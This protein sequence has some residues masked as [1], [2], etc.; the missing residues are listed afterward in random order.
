SVAVAAFGQKLKGVSAL[1]DYAYGSILGL[2]EAAKGN[3]P[4]GYRA[5]FVKLVRLAEGLAGGK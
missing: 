5:E 3:D 2:A 4:F 1:Q